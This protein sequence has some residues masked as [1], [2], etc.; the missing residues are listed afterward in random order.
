MRTCLHFTATLVLLVI[1]LLF[2]PARRVTGDRELAG[3]PSLEPAPPSGAVVARSFADLC[4]DDP[5]GAVASSI[6]KYRATVERY[7]C[8][9]HRHERIDGKLHDPER[10]ECEFRDSPFAVR[11]HWVGATE[12]PETVLY[13]AGENQ[14]MFL[15]IPAN[16]ALKKTLGLLGRN[17]AKR[18]LDGSD[19]KSASRYPPNEFG[20]LRG[21]E[22]V[23]DAWSAANDRGELRTEYV[24]LLPVPELGGKPCHVL[25]RT[26]L[27]PEEDG[28]T[29]V[30][31]QFDPDTLLQ[32]G[33]VLMAGD[34]LIGRYHFADLKLNPRLS[35]DRFSPDTLK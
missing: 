10:V 11:M 4:R 21:T 17:Y 19:A 30:T 26:C 5:L 20:I 35:A 9:L 34:D 12:G 25:R 28:L 3:R 8:V 13:A 32:V 6:R 14:E 22:R 16:P 7:T 31:I 2:A 1:C 33:A 24:G 29:Q 23:Y 27:A 18:R 15:V